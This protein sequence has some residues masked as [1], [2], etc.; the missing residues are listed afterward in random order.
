MNR[1]KKLKITLAT[2]LCLIGGN[3]VSN[4]KVNA[5]TPKSSQVSQQ[6]QSQDA[7]VKAV[8]TIVKIYVGFMGFILI[9]GCFGL[10]IAEML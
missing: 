4:F 7:E 10:L 9:V 3:K 1:F 5:E 2:V 6:T 8:P